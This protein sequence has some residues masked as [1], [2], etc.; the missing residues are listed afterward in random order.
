MSEGKELT[1]GWFE[2]YR[3][4]CVSEIVARKKDLIG[5]CGKHGAESQHGS[6]FRLHQLLNEPVTPGERPHE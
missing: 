3:C 6:P 5:Y 1:R 2:A 4:G